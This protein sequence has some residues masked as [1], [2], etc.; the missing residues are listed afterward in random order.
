[1]N[2]KRY[3]IVNRPIFH[4]NL[5]VNLTAEILLK[6]FT[7]KIAQESFDNIKRHGSILTFW[8]FTNRIIIITIITKLNVLQLKLGCFATTQATYQT[9]TSTL[10]H[11]KP[12]SCAK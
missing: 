4:L 10:R 1:V 7:H 5:S 6:L 2:I 8:R 12:I 11:L 9:L 3:L